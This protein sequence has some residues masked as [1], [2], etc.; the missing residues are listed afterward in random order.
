MKYSII[1][2]FSFINMFLTFLQ[3]FFS[4]NVSKVLITEDALQ[5]IGLEIGCCLWLC[6]KYFYTTAQYGLRK[7]GI[8]G[9]CCTV[10]YKHAMAAYKNSC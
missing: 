9:I 4:G 10:V 1:K 8:A 2:M 5:Y 7:F 6:F 3:I